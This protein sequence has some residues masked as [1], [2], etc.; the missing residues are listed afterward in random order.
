MFVIK[1][2][3]GK[4]ESKKAQRNCAKTGNTEPCTINPETGIYRNRP[5][6]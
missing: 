4:E 3:D 1:K 5:R 6:D 2:K